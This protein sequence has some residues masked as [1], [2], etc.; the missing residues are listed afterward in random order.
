MSQAQ[1]KALRAKLK[2]KETEIGRTSDLLDRVQESAQSIQSALRAGGFS[3]RAE[4][5]AFEAGLRKKQ[6]RVARLG[7]ELRKLRRQS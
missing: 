4:R 1:I 5:T 7:E 2:A 3:N 6:V